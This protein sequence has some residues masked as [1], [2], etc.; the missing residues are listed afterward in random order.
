MVQ[1]GRST[2]VTIALADLI[3]QLAMQVANVALRQKGDGRCEW[4]HS[5]ITGTCKRGAFLVHDEVACVMDIDGRRIPDETEHWSEEQPL[6]PGLHEVFVRYYDGT[7]TGGN[8]FVIYAVPGAP[9]LVRFNHQPNE[10]PTVWIENEVTH[11]RA[12][13]LAEAG[14][15]KPPEQPDSFYGW[16]PFG[17]W[18]YPTGNPD[19]VKPAVQR[20]K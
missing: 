7:S 3:A 10:K 16:G 20:S 6:L 18:S 2:A 13:H 5:E 8:S 9:Y 14:M 11:E 19:Y 4:R 15:G 12:T 1:P 17:A